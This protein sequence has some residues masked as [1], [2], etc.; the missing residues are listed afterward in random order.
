M[1]HSRVLAPSESTT[2]ALNEDGRWIVR[3]VIAGFGLMAAAGA[4]LWL[5]Y[6]PS[7]FFDSLNALTGCF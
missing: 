5:H 3:S 6:G 4:A 1:D 2:F 7:I